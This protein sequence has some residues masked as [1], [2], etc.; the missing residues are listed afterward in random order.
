[1][2]IDKKWQIP[3][4]MLPQALNHIKYVERDH[5]KMWF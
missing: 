2:C 5:L 1:V 3:T 4:D